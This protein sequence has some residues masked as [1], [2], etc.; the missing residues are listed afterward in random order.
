MYY[1]YLNR[2]HHQRM[3]LLYI[4]VILTTLLCVT[5]CTV[6]N[7][8]PSGNNKCYN[9]FSLQQY[10]LNVTKKF[11]S[12]TELHFLSGLHHLPTDLI[13]QNVHN[14]SL[15]GSTTNGMTSDT[16]I[17]CTSSVNWYY[18]N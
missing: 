18:N 10:L 2:F 8:T 16:V 6:Y 14:I 17:Q 9:C 15:I 13:I 12:N 4:T 7:V 1:N 5:S 11:T 3:P